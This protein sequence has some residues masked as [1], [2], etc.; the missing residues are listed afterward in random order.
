M[1]KMKPLPCSSTV[2]FD[3]T[4]TEKSSRLQQYSQ[5]LSK[6]EQ[7]YLLEMKC[8]REYSRLINSTDFYLE[9]LLKQNLN[10][11]QLLLHHLNS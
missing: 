8:G 7:G 2:A 11:S 9:E 3:W 4:D 5:L 1:D 10:S 6:C